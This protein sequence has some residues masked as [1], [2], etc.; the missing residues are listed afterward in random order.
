MDC[1]VEGLSLI[2]R[3]H[4]PCGLGRQVKVQSCAGSGEHSGILGISLVQQLSPGLSSTPIPIFQSNCPFI[5]TL[6]CPKGCAAPSAPERQNN[7]VMKRTDS[8]PRLSEMNLRSKLL[9]FSRLQF[10]HL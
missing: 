1:D 3:D 2:Q 5:D 6:Y 4:V 10:P 9:N 8:V 7:T